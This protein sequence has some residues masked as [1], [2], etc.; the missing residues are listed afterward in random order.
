MLSI[1]LYNY[2]K[3][4]KNEYLGRAEIDLSFL[5]Y[6]EGNKTGTIPIHLADVPTGTLFVHL[7]YEHICFVR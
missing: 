2:R 6:Y 5:K 7:S 4:S 1:Q 3:Y